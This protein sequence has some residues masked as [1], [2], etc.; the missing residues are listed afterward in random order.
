MTLSLSELAARRLR[1]DVSVE[2]GDAE[3]T[4]RRARLVR[5]AT[6][7]RGGKRRRYVWLW[8]ILALPAGWLTGWYVVSMDRAT[9]FTAAGVAGHVGAFYTAPQ[10]DALAL[11]F[12]DG[13]EVRLGAG[14]HARVLRSEAGQRAVVLELGHAEASLGSYRGWKWELSAGPFLIETSQA[15]LVLSWDVAQQALAVKLRSGSALVRGPGLAEGRRLNGS[16]ELTTK[17]ATS[18]P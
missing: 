11:R 8:L 14:S 6:G 17:V 3:Y 16:E 15:D 9:S 2:Q 12:G 7:E 10:S 1:R 18:P 5:A 13:S 4:E